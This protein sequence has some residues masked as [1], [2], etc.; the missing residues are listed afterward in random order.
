[1]PNNITG[2]GAAYQV[3]L[4]TDTL[5]VLRVAT[6]TASEEKEFDEVKAYP[7][8]DCAPMSDVDIAEKQ[9]SMTVTIGSPSLDEQ[10]ISFLLFNNKFRTTASIPL[11]EYKRGIITG[12]AVVDTDLTIDQ[13]VQ[14]TV[15]SDFAPGNTPLT[16]QPSGTGVTGNIFEVAAGQLNFDASL[17]GKTIAYRYL[18]SYTNIKTLGGEYY[19]P[20]KKIQIA[21]KVCGTRFNGMKILFPSCTSLSGMNLDPSADNFDREYKALVPTELGFVVPYIVWGFAS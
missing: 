9:S 18:K 14:V 13:R 12:G 2:V 11:P 4:E 5:N 15:I 6:F 21:G 19:D 8:L 1:M 20:Y 16:R 3:D 7:L 10:A 17:E